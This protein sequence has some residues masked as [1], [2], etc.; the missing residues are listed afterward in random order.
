MNQK[1]YPSFADYQSA[2]QHPEMAFS[3]NFLRYAAVESDLWGF[4]RVRSGGFALTYKVATKDTT[5]AA[6]CFHRAVRDRAIRYARI[7]QSLEEN[8]L[9]YFVSTR[10]ISR[11]VLVNGKHFPIS[12]LE[13]VEGESL[14]T[15][16]L[17]NLNNREKLINLSEKFRLMCRDLEINGIAHGDL[18]HRNIIVKSDDNLCL[19]DYDG[20]YVPSLAG[21]KS[22]ELGNIHFQ[23]PGRTNVV[24]NSHLDRFSSIVIFLALLALAENPSLWG[25]FQSGGEGLLFQKADF[26]APANSLLISALEKTSLT[27][28]YIHEFRQVCQ[29]AVEEV[30]SLEDLIHKQVPALKIHPH[31]WDL[32]ERNNLVTSAIPAENE[33]KIRSMIGEIVTVVGKVTEVFHGRTPDGEDHVFVNFGNWEQGC[34]TCVLWG[35]VLEE[36]MKLDV[37]MDE[38]LGQWM[39]IHGLVLVRKNRPQ[40]QAEM[41][42]DCSVLSSEDK[43]IELL[44]KKSQNDMIVK[45][46]EKESGQSQSKRKKGP[47]LV[48]IVQP[49]K[50][51]KGT[52]FQLEN[53]FTPTTNTKIEEV[54]NQLYSSS[55]FKARKKRRQQK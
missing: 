12:I 7:C 2:L 9:Q 44:E 45:R 47:K 4:P 13:W 5:Y 40:I 33:E 38:W 19:I 11:G 24:F 15:F 18:S 10:Y 30:P 54:I 20:L 17:H 16:V 37:A 36:F 50:K 8:K 27:A 49:D 28:S 6:R 3:A 32:V 53:I 51:I 29:S 39:R 35:S 43:A 21:R 48:G 55:R 41:I 42:T 46:F 14:E 31:L 1:S 52:T 26:L 25:R 22:S 23:H 34:F